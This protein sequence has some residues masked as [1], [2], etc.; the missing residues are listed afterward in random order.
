MFW[1]QHFGSFGSN[2][3]DHDI[4]LC[5]V[6]YASTKRDYFRAKRIIH[7]YEDSYKQLYE[8]LDELDHGHI[9][10]NQMNQNVEPKTFF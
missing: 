9:G 10:S 4:P 2:Q 5:G 6:F 1:V 8:H 7:L 3:Y